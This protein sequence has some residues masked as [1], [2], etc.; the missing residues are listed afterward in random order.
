MSENIYGHFA[1]SSGLQLN[2]ESSVFDKG[3]FYRG[4][5]LF[6]AQQPSAGLPASLPEEH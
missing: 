1:I 3:M 2:L 6:V 4:A 5:S